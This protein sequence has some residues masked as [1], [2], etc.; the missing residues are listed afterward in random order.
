MTINDTYLT[1]ET[2][3]KKLRYVDNEKAWEEFVY[4][5]QKFIF[6]IIAKMGVSG[7]DCEDLSQKVLIKLWKKL[8]DFQYNQRKG[9]FRSWLYV[10]TKNTVYNFLKKQ[11]RKAEKS[12]LA[13]ELEEFEKKES[14]V[15]SFIDEEWKR[16]LTVLACKNINKKMSSKTLEAFQSFVN[17]EPVDSIAKRLDISEKTVYKYKSR[18]KEKLMEEIKHLKDMLE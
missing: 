4:F 5:Y 10:I 3:L 7:P 15:D 17:G 8:P 13:S 1:R 6:S 2:L 14:G 16:H 9:A 12:K 18:V 11:N